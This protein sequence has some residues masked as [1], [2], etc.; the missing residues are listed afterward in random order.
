MRK[1]L[2]HKIE[3][4]FS[5]ENII[6]LG[7]N[8]D[9]LVLLNSNIGEQIQDDPYMRYDLLAGLGS[10]ETQSAGNILEQLKENHRLK[11]DWL[12]GYLSYDFKN[13]L[14]NLTSS[15]PDGVGAGDFFF[16]RPRYVFALRDN[17]LRL[18]YDT[19]AD[20]AQSAQTII[21]ELL[22]AE[23][24]PPT[25]PG[26]VMQTRT[27]RETY[28]RKFNEIQNH[29]RRGDIYEMNFCVEF[30]AA[31][32]RILPE[33][34]YLSLNRLSPMP[35]SSFVRV[36]NH[37]VLCASPERFLAKRNRKIISQPIKGTIRRGKDFREDEELKEFLYRDPKERSENVMI[38][39]LV[40]NDL[41]RTAK[42]NSVQVEELFGIRTFRRLHQMVSTVTSE[43]AHDRHF[44]EAIRYAF[45]MGSMTGA[46]KVSAM[47]LIEEIEEAKR[48]IYSGS[49]GYI[50]PDGDFDFN[51]VIRSII[52]NSSSGYLSYMAGSAITA[53]ADAGKEYD[54]CLLKAETM[55]QVL[56]KPVSI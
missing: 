14:E 36:G 44:T 53:G 33:S 43:L 8:F 11:S 29:I 28:L 50:S 7:R 41:A 47:R 18:Y 48:G 38:V 56:S 40:R 55:Q 45:P 27:G 23:R 17:L 21:R 37:Y 39:D 31:Q 26:I 20:D 16:F 12:F 13:R 3:D 49:V 9:P 5:F 25:G 54:E 32:A 42:R 4:S 19:A 46:P 2:E 1:W 24:I 15:N 6:S 52:Y 35:F 34:V 30:F 22:Q 51:V 10:L